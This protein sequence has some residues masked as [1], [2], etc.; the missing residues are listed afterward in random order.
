MI[1]VLL[2]FV[3][4][5][6]FLRY[7]LSAYNS[8][9][10][11]IFLLSI[12]VLI[13]ALRWKV[14]G[15]SL[16]YQYA[17]ENEIPVIFDVF[18]YGM[19][20]YK[21]EPCFTFIMILSK[22][23]IDNFIFFQ[24][25]HSLFI[26]LVFFYCFKKYLKYKFLAVLI[27]AYFQFLYFN[28]EIL[29]ESISVCFFILIYPYYSTRQWLKYYLG[30]FIALFFHFSALILFF[31]PLLKNFKFNLVFL[32]S[33][34]LMMTFLLL[35]SHLEF[36]FFDSNFYFKS[37]IDRFKL[38]SEISNRGVGG[39]FLST[40]IFIIIPCVIYSF[41]KVNFKIY[42]FK[43]L[44]FPYILFALLNIFYGGF[45]RLINYFSFFM[46]V[47]FVKL[48]EE[49]LRSIRFRQ[50]KFILLFLF[51]IIPVLYKTHYYYQS[52][53]HYSPNTIRLNAWYPYSSCITKKEYSFREE[54]FRGTQEAK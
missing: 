2:L 25:I 12:F 32:F 45:N 13:S 11:Y 4:F 54:I 44:F 8:D 48:V 53:S 21:W 47:V 19:W 5:I 50:V 49:L 31:I 38:Y 1:Y 14:G 36:G 15:D 42:L 40:F 29:R 10:Q 22:S 23:I 34:F 37:F 20:Y 52:T 28:M 7:D 30:A 9:T 17:F 18:K 27:Y 41:L 33:F 46:I 24:F 39:M 6:C 16:F 26:N 51:M 43:D 3:I 35:F